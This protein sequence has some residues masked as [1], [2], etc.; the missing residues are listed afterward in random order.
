VALPVLCIRTRM[1]GGPVSGIGFA[2]FL[3]LTIRTVCPSTLIVALS[4]VTRWTFR[5]LNVSLRP[6]THVL[7]EGRPNAALAGTGRGLDV[8]LAVAM[9]APARSAQVS[10]P[11]ATRSKRT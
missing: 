11:T 3:P 10:V 9:A 4:Q 8:A 2:S 7:V 1:L 6:V 5:T